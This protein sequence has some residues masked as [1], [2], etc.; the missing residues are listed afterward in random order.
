M[1][2][3]ENKDEHLMFFYDA[4][5]KKM[6][7]YIASALT[8]FGAQVATFY[9]VGGRGLSPS[10]VPGVFVLSSLL[11]LSQIFL[12]L[13]IV[14]KFQE[15]VVLDMRLGISS[16]YGLRHRFHYAKLWDALFKSL[17]FSK[18]DDAEQDNY[19]RMNLVLDLVV[20]LLVGLSTVFFGLI[21]AQLL[22]FHW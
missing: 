4:Q 11:W 8:S 12:V 17:L 9:F 19:P 18:K 20:V 7:A 1:V 14:T 15:L 22:N 16:F 21:L 5:L 3:D 2:L 10:S 6:L 13:A